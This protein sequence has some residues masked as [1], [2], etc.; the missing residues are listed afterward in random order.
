LIDEPIT[1]TAIADLHAFVGRCVVSGNVRR[2]AEILLGEP[3]DQEFLHLKD[4]VLHAEE[5][6]S[7][8]YI[9]N[10]SILATSGMSYQEIAELTVKNGEPGYVWLDN[11]RAYG[12][13]KDP[14][15]WL[16]QR[17]VGVNPCVEQTLWN[18]ELCNLVE[19]FPA[20]HEYE[21]DITATLKK[22]YLFAKIVTLIPTHSP[23]TNAV[24]VRN[25]RIG[26]S[27]S[28]IVS[29]VHKFGYREFFNICD[30]GY[31]YLS[32][33]DTQY[34]AWLGVHPSIKR[35]SVKPSGTI[36]KLPGEKEG[37]HYD[38]GEFMIQ[39]IRAP[40]S[41]PL[42]EAV[43]TAGYTV[44]ADVT[45]PDTRVVIEFPV[46]DRYFSRSVYE[47]SM[48]E[49]L[50]LAAAMQRYWA[51]NQVSCTVKF[52]RDDPELLEEIRCAEKSVQLAREAVASCTG[53]GT[54][55][56][57]AA[58]GRLRTLLDDQAT[59]RQEIAKELTVALEAFEDQLKGISFLPTEHGYKQP[60]KQVISEQRY[61]EM[62]SKLRPLSLST[63]VTHEV[64]DKF[65]DGEA[66]TLN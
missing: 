64:E 44:E 18:H 27:M 33:L 2:S 36:S 45:A 30:R 15:N 59:R 46:R 8:R 21:A 53:C 22:A 6:S 20:R 61:H 12:R 28:G 62:V 41:S 52:E 43:I 58:E 66:C 4:P 10:N 42:V 39:R 3:D 25:R 37:I 51:D 14:P 47:V 48:W 17:A 32:E 24:I 13:M 34:S 19:V 26:T 57:L 11:A 54:G 40:R 31:K 55:V 35:T 56:V 5:L 7:H 65:C 29:A 23:Q 49:Q 63:T 50:S 60:P 1:G 16:D 38:E 9:S